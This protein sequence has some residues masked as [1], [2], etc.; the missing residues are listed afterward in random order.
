M[1]TLAGLIGWLFPRAGRGDAG[2]H[3][4]L[5]NR[6]GCPEGAHAGPPSAA[7]GRWRWLEVELVALVGLL[8]AVG[9]AVAFTRL[10]G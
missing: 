3:A 10:A 7:P 4:S 5:W 9:A 8:A 6:L 1:N 2:L